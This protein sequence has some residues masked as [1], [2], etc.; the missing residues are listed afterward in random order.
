MKMQ[1]VNRLKYS[2]KWFRSNLLHRYLW[3][4]QRWHH[5]WSPCSMAEG[6]EPKG[7]ELKKPAIQAGRIFWIGSHRPCKQTGQS[8]WGRKWFR[9]LSYRSRQQTVVYR[10]K[11]MRASIKVDMIFPILSINQ[12]AFKH[13]H[14][15]AFLQAWF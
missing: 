1:L 2:F 7:Q 3:P 13:K 15:L 4:V 10:S 8:I 9:L 14:N 12:Y 11:L 5:E 6:K